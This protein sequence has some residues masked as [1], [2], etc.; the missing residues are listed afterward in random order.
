[1]QRI[2]A[3]RT[4]TTWQRKSIRA[5]ERGT[6]RKARRRIMRLKDGMLYNNA[7]F[8]DRDIDLVRNAGGTRTNKIN[9]TLRA[10]PP[11]PQTGEAE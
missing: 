3:S 11:L 10:F 2:A 8:A 1:M 9:P 7:R 5:R 6:E 4:P